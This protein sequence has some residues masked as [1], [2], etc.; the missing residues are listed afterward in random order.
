MP[1]PFSIRYTKPLR[2]VIMPNNQRQVLE[3]IKKRILADKADNIVMSEESVTYKGS[4]S[5]NKR[6]ALFESVDCGS[7]TL[8]NK[9]NKWCLVYK[10]KMYK[11]FIFTS[12]MAAFM[13]LIA[14]IG[15]GDWWI[16]IIMFLWLCGMNWIISIIR[17]EDV[18]ARIAIGI[19]ELLGYH[20][21]EDT[22]GLKSWF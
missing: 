22:E 10:I 18:A 16:G 12:L 1:F 17:H 5:A 15:N 3:Y 11:L 7:F 4:T 8:S 13:G 6:H 14:Q 19:N 20:T 2:A 21:I 9:G